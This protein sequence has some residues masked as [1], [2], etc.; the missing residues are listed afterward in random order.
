M[1][2][3]DQAI[4]D[5]DQAIELTPRLI[6]SVQATIE[7]R[8][9]TGES[10]LGSG[11]YTGLMNRETY[12]DLPTAYAGPRYGLSTKRRL[13][14]SCLG[15][16]EGHPAGSPIG[17]R[18]TGGGAS[19]CF[20]VGISTRFNAGASTGHW[21]KHQIRAVIRG[22]SLLTFAADGQ[23]RDFKLS[24]VFGPDNYCLVDSQDVFLEAD[25]IFSFTFDPYGRG[26]GILTQGTFV[27]STLVSGSFSGTIS[28][29]Q[30]KATHLNGGQSQGDSWSAQWV[31]GPEPDTCV[32]SENQATCIS[33]S[34][35]LDANEVVM[36]NVHQG[37][38]Q[39]VTMMQ[40]HL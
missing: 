18:A 32:V 14:A 35:F 39:W 21:E 23:I 40:P 33:L 6:F 17:P 11:F 7:S 20:H 15:P 34:D 22:R 28:C 10:L 36:I 1:G 16:E 5:F 27:S 2:N 26:N 24:L 31:S 4:A 9:P 13:P 12:A 38:S 37:H 30:P 3:Y 19:G 29:I 8:K 25:G